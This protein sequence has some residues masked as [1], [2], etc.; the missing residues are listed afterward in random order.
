[1]YKRV[2]SVRPRRSERRLRAQRTAKGIEKGDIAKF[3]RHP[4]VKWLKDSNC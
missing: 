3:N 2:K 1:M 4:S